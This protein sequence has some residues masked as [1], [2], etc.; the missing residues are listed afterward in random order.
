[1]TAPQLLAGLLGLALAVAAY[2][3]G[4]EAWRPLAW[5]RA[6]AGLAVAVLA[7]GFLIQLVPY[8]HDHSNPPV[9]AE[10]AWDSPQTRQLARRACFDCHSNQVT[11]PWYSNVAPLAWLIQSSVDEGRSA[12]NL[13]EFDRPQEEAGEA[14]ETVQEGSMPPRD[15][16]L[17]HPDARLS[18]ADEAALIRGLSATLGGEGGDG[19]HDD[20]DDDDD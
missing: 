15:Y 11:W 19:N 17:L 10:P 18:D 9:T 1:M 7:L 2:R 12:L 14:A 13:S 4:R 20:D 8:G 3:L 5:P 16:L 6:A